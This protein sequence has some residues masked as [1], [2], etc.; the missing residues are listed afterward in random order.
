VALRRTDGGWL[1]RETSFDRLGALRQKEQRNSGF[2]LPKLARLSRWIPRACPPGQG[3]RLRFSDDDR[4]W[5]C[6]PWAG[7]H[8]CCLAG[9]LASFLR[10]AEQGD[11]PADGATPDPPRRRRPGVW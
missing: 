8:S 11:T 4:N 10:S 2:E 3:D 5:I 6:C 9:R 1:S 7:P